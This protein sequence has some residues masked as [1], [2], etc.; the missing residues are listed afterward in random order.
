MPTQHGPLG[1]QFDFND[2]CRVVLPEGELRWRVRL[3]DIDTAN[4]LFETTFSTGRINSTKRYY[5]RG[6][7][8]V[9]S[10][11]Q[12]D[13]QD[14]LVFS[15]DYSA[16]D[17]DI[18]IQF[19]V[20][21]IGDTMGWF[22]YAVKFKEQ[23]GCK[24]TCAM[25]EKLIPLFRDVYPDITFVTHEEVK[26]DRFYA[27]YSI[28]LFFDDKD[29]IFQ[30]CDFRH[31]GLHRTAGYIL[32]V[33]PAEKP[34]LLALA[35]DG[36]PID[37]PYVCIAVQSTTQAKYW[38]NPDGWRSIVKF[39]KRV[40]LSRDLHRSETDARRRA[41]L[42]PHSQ[43]GGGRD[44][45]PPIAGTCALAQACRL[46]RRSFQRAVMARM[47]YWHTGRD[48]LGLFPSTQR[49]QHSV[50]GDQLPHLQQ[51]LERPATALRSQ[52]FFVVS[53]PQGHAAAV[54][55]HSA[56]Y[57]GSGQSRHPEN[58]AIRKARKR[59]REISNSEKS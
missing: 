53:A 1:I 51:L 59:S 12:Q 58:P 20:G 10:Q 33:D 11:D 46:L 43:W 3:S 25:G 47:G 23:H 13:K 54:R 48:D 52:G 32:G 39:L 30:P 7:I 44:R 21:T 16:K 34:P 22:P 8:E 2:G 57:R 6:R 31:V 40:R 5:L 55:V 42:E 17:R 18:L 4:I 26:T 9:W 24:L 38:T 28:G 14:K 37:E 36:R 49:V 35:D 41:G 56:D 19:P 45:R 15:H 29:H 50:S 27:T